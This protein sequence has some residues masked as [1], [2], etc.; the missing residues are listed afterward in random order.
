LGPQF[1]ELLLLDGE[2]FTRNFFHEVASCNSKLLIKSKE[3][4]RDV[5][6][7]AQLLFQAKD[8]F[9]GDFLQETGFDSQ[10]C[11]HW[12]IQI[13]SGEYAELPLQVAHL[14]E[15]YFKRKV[16]PHLECWIVTTDLSLLPAEIREAAHLRWHV[17]NNVFKRLSKQSG[18]KR[19]H[20]KDPARFYSLLRLFCAAAALFD[21]LVAILQRA[22]KSF[23]GILD[24]IKLTWNNLFS[25]L[26]ESFPE[27][28][29]TDKSPGV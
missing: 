2:Y 11:C 21:M 5:H 12:S 4:F 26:A 14:A 18:T 22:Q 7:D 15:H 27:S 8:R 3:P 10:R 19:F 6:Q 23:K 28:A 1:P 13:T 25:R 9:P 16:E 17:E 20:F 29:L 24:G